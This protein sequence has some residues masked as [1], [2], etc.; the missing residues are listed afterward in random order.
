MATP[1][2]EWVGYVRDTIDAHSSDE[3]L[4]VE[5][6]STIRYSI[7][8]PA[9]PP[10]PKR[11]T[12]AALSPYWISKSDDGTKV[13]VPW[14]A[15]YRDHRQTVAAPSPACAH[16]TNDWSRRQ[17]EKGWTDPHPRDIVVIGV[18]FDGVVLFGWYVRF[19][20]SRNRLV[21][22]PVQ[23]CK[24]VRVEMEADKELCNSS[25]NLNFLEATFQRGLIDFDAVAALRFE[26]VKA[27]L[28]KMNVSN[29]KRKRDCP[30]SMSLCSNNCNK[31]STVSK[32]GSVDTLFT[33]S[34]CLED[35][36]IAGHVC[37]GA[38]G[39]T[40]ADCFAKL[41]GYCPVCERSDIN[42][43]YSCSNCQATVTLQQYGFPCLTC[44]RRVLCTCCYNAFGECG[45][46]DILSAEG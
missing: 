46:C 26:R 6:E 27:N 13:Q 16:C 22:L 29:N 33:C 12:R 7:E 11:T 1:E 3:F 28:K 41:R 18:P 21:R 35:S 2:E 5:P 36:E 10:L 30:K 37:C 45:E 20:N 34:V 44:E 31:S 23:I 8:T 38:P 32:N 24:S 15:I 43:E 42:A 40:C 4:E 14:H 39:N 25:L 19:Q 17:C 9:L